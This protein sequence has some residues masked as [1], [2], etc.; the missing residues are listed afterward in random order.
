MLKI[1]NRIMKKDKVSEEIKNRYKNRLVV[2]YSVMNFMYVI[3][4]ILLLIILYIF[5]TDINI[6]DLI[7]GADYRGIFILIFLLLYQIV[8]IPSLYN[9]LKRGLK[10]NR[11]NIRLFDNMEFKEK[12]Y[13]IGKYILSFLFFGYMII[14]FSPDYNSGFKLDFWDFAF[15]SMIFSI[16]IIGL[17]SSTISMIFLMGTYIKR[18]KYYIFKYIY[19]ESDERCSRCRKSKFIYQQDEVQI[20]INELSNSDL[21]M[22]LNNMKINLNGLR[23]LKEKEQEDI[24]NI[25]NISERL[26]WISNIS[27]AERISDIPSSR[28]YLKYIKNE[29]ICSRCRKKHKSYLSTLNTDT[30]PIVYKISNSESEKNKEG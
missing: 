8:A 29:Y 11:K 23:D 5:Q 14:L 25:G 27:E 4:A 13:E 7:D 9:V 19:N 3:F 15:Y 24:R 16:G 1:Q 18:I 2:S 21:C 12:M 6:Y 28:L 10:I 20:N 26:K 17:L 22:Y 30:I